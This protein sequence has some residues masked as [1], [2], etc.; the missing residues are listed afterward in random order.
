MLATNAAEARCTGSFETSACQMLSA[1]NSGHDAVLAGA[2]GF[3]VADGLNVADS[4]GGADDG[5]VTDPAV[6]ASDPEAAEPFS[7]P[8]WQPLRSSVPDSRIPK[9]RNGKSTAVTGR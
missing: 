6:L 9:A 4:V 7:A 5:G 2:D 8:D 3:G 1:G